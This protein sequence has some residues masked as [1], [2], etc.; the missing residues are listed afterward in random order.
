MRK[1]NWRSVG[2]LLMCLRLE[3]Y[4]SHGGLFTVITGLQ[5]SMVLPGPLGAPAPVPNDEGDVC[6]AGEGHIALGH[7]AACTVMLA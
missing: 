7:A 1:K 4:A 6:F 2:V 5:A 3:A